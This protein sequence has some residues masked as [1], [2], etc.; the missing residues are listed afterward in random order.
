MAVMGL[1]P[2]VA[3][4]Q[5]QAPTATVPVKPFR[6]ATVVDLKG[7]TKSLGQGVLDGLKAGLDEQTI[8]GRR[9]QLLVENDFGQPNRTQEAV[10]NL[11]LRKPFAFLGNTGIE[12]TQ[13]VQSALERAAV[14]GVGFSNGLA[15]LRK[16]PN[17]LNF[18]ASL[19]QEVVAMIEKAITAGVA[20]NQI[21]AFVENS[22]YGMIGVKGLLDS[23]RGHGAGP[24]V[25]STLERILSAEGEAAQRNGIGPVGVYRPKTFGSRAAYDSLKNW[26]KAQG[27]Q[28]RFVVAVGSDTTVGRFIGYSRYKKESWIIGILS[29]TDTETLIEDLKRFND[30][31]SVSERLVMSEV[32][33]GVES[34]LAIVREARAALGDGFNRASLEGYIV[35]KL[36]LHLA[37]RLEGGDLTPAGFLRAAQGSVVDLDGLTL[38]FRNGNQGSNWVGLTGYSDGEWGPMTDRLWKQWTE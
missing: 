12:T 32:V 24:Q 11:L 2:V 16:S 29:G 8:D 37:H 33:P 28:C 25:L 13:E 36:F 9:V 35:A 10:A 7:K 23:L 19:N 30:F 22:P 38:D 14:P 3:S 17:F 1:M 34:D 4:A 5:E 20:A 27:A 18:R 21:C 31:K 26:E 15:S 6:V